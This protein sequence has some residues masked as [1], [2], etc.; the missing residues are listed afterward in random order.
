MLTVYQKYPSDLTDQQWDIIRRLVPRARVG[1]RPRTTDVR[2]VINAV[3]YLCR[4]G[5]AWRY[6]PKHFGPWQTIYDYFSQWRRKGFWKK[7]NDVLSMKARIEAKK[8]R[9]PSVLIIDS[10]SIRAPQGKDRGYDGFKKLRGRKRH[11][12][13]DTL[14]LIHSLK[15]HPANQPDSAY[16]GLVFKDLNKP[17]LSRIYADLGY[18]GAFVQKTLETFGFK[19]EMP[20]TNPLSGQGKPKTAKAKLAN[21]RLRGVPKKRWI[22]ERTFAWFNHY[23]RLSKDYERLPDTSESMIYLAMSQLILRRLA[24]PEKLL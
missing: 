13:V 5:C 14:G 10:Q 2:K 24:P 9:S 16:G 19:P 22:V 3:F 21:R 4:T 23:R 1:G 18:R 8:L 17:R 15:V 11:L 20:P 6:L 7:L 12:L